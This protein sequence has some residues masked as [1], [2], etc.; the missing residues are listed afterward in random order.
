MGVYRLTVFNSNGTG[1]ITVS[2]FNV[3]GLYDEGDLIDVSVTPGDGFTFAN[4]QVAVFRARNL[5]PHTFQAG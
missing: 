2:P 4:W 5:T 1:E 3:L